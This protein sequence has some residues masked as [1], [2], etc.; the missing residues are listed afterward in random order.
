MSKLRR[1]IV[2]SVAAVLCACS[3][4]ANRPP[5][6]GG[7]DQTRLTTTEIRNADPNLTLYDLINRTRP[8]WL[9]RRAG[10]SLQNQ[11]DVAVYRDDI[12]VGG[13]EVLTEI[14]LDIVVSARYLTASEATNRFGL[15]HPHG[16]ILVTTRRE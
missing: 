10:T 16:A 6:G 1:W 7:E 5:G 12:R 11:F 13:R 2:L 8:Q 15:N 3:T 9:V 14:R 4:R